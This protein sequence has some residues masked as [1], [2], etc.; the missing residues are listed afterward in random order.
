VWR[1][2]AVFSVWDY[3]T[4]ALNEV[5]ERDQLAKALEHKQSE[6]AALQ[7]ASKLLNTPPYITHTQ[8][9]RAFAVVWWAMA[10]WERVLKLE[11]DVAS[12]STDPDILY[13]WLKKNRATQTFTVDSLRRSLPKRHPH[14]RRKAVLA[15]A[16]KA[17][18]AD[19]RLHFNTKDSVYS[20]HP[21]TAAVLS[22]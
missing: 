19:G 13:S 10:E 4:E 6:S 3:A 11:G 8:L 7:H 17:L 5:D 16:L 1:I 2:A 22:D 12:D 21:I 18:A 20:L 15:K 9:E 14:L